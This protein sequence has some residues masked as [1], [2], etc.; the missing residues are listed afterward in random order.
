MYAH[1]LT[2]RSDPS[3]GALEV[4]CAEHALGVA[5]QVDISQHMV[6]RIDL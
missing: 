3:V 6:G 1:R 4:V 2:I 5:G